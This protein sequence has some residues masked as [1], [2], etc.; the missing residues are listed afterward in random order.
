MSSP[1]RNVAWCSS[2]DKQ[3]HYISRNIQ[4]CAWT[5]PFFD[6]TASNHA[7]GASCGNSFTQAV[8]PPTLFKPLRD[9][10]LNASPWD[11]LRILTKPVMGPSSPSFSML[12]LAKASSPD[13]LVSM[14]ENGQW[15]KGLLTKDTARI[16]IGAQKLTVSLHRRFGS[17]ARHVGASH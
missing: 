14:W 3:A 7:N 16:E 8:V 17:Q 2:G 5:R 4:R 6:A 13:S 12:R 11:R 15:S 10:R 1:T 9:P